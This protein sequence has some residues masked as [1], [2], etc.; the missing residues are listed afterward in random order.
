M[1][2]SDPWVP[3]S[4]E[5]LFILAMDHR[6]SFAKDLFGVTGT[7]AQNELVKMRQAKA[8]VYEGLRHVAERP[9]RRPAGCPSRR[10]LRRRRCQN[11][12]IRRRRPV[13]AH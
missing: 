8:L 5:P 6:N 3:S 11:G 7:P 9:C 1:N 10:G 12:Q 4:D 13:D 2:A